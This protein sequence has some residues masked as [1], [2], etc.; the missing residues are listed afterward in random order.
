MRPENARGALLGLA[1]GDALGLPAEYHRHARAGWGRGVLWE[2]NVDLDRQRISRP[3]LPFVPGHTEL[4]PLCGT[5]DTETA[6]TAA[7][8]LLEA[9]AHD[10]RS[11]F[12]EWRTHY[13]DTEDVWCG[14]AERGAVLHALEGRVPPV[15]GTDNPVYWDDGAVPAAVSVGLFHS[16]DTRKATETATEYARITHDRDGV[17][18]AGAMAHAIAALSAGEH[19]TAALSEAERTVPDDSW[20]RRGLERA[21]AIVPDRAE[22]VFATVPSLIDAFGRPGYSHGGVAPETLPLAFAITR[23]VEGDL[24][25]GLQTAA[26]FPRQSDSLPAMVGALCGATG[27]DDAVPDTWRDHVDLVEGVLLP[28]VAGQRLTELADRL[29]TPRMS[30]E[31]LG[32][33]TR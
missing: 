4:N 33:P 20:L 22:G 5:D 14:I 9:G 3:L 25:S 23:L 18:A 21:A 28:R 11:L 2:K 30:T 27:G 8:V 31:H 15:T 17:W 32:A 19:L 24:T 12:Q 7:L 1:M 26:L 10:L 16:G 6:A 29:V 13:V